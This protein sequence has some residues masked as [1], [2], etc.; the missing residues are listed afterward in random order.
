MVDLTARR[1]VNNVNLTSQTPVITVN[2][3]NTGNTEADREALARML[4]TVLLEQRAAGAAMTIAP[5][6]A[7]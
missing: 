1:Y 5:R 2:G 3:Q 7:F 6:L 4:E